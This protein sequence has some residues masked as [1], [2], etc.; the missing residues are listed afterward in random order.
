MKLKKYILKDLILNLRHTLKT[1]V[2]G[3]AHIQEF[4]FGN[5]VHEGESNAMN[6]QRDFLIYY[7]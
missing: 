1:A 2:P 3:D 6:V 5:V 7:F 4:G